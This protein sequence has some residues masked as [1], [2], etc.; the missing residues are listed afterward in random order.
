MFSEKQ[1]GEWSG[2]AKKIAK[3]TRSI[4]LGVSHADGSYR[5]SGTSIPISFAYDSDG[6]QVYQSKND[7]RSFIIDLE[8][9][10]VNFV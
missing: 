1:F 9:M 2:R 4:F 10:E 6:N 8:D 3:E 5:D 7:T